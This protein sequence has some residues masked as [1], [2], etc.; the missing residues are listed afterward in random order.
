MLRYLCR[1][2]GVLQVDVIRAVGLRLRNSAELPDPLVRC[3]LQ[4]HVHEETVGS[5][6]KY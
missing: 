4:P 5:P 1:H 2:R 3:W 6:Q